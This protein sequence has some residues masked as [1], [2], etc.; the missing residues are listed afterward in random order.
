MEFKDV[1]I[2]ERTYRIG[3]YTPKV[4]GYITSQLLPLLINHLPD[5]GPDGKVN[6]SI[7]TFF[8]ALP[9]LS[10]Q[11]YNKIVDYSL[12]ICCEYNQEK[13]LIPI[14]MGNGQWVAKHLEHDT[15][16]VMALVVAVLMHNLQPF[17]S[18]GG[19]QTILK[20]TQDL[21]Q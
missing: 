9:D 20:V 8:K 16:S 14:V 3:E 2:K 6:I 21:S 15:V 5:P 4:G 18:E 11:I 7:A 10:E 17:F 12:A 19:L 13:M 1:E